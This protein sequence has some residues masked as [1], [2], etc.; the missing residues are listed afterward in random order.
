MNKIQSLFKELYYFEIEQK[1]KI[2]AQLGIPLTVLVLLIGVIAYYFKKLSI[3]LN[4]DVLSL[5]FLFLL[6]V[7]I[8]FVIADIYFLFR[9]FFGYK[10]NYLPSS[11]NLDDYVESLK[12]YYKD[13]YFSKLGQDEIDRQID[14]DVDSFL[15]R[16]YKKCLDGNI[17]NNA[18]KSKYL[19][20]SCFSL[21]FIVVFIILSSI[22]YSI[23]H[24]SYPNIQKIE[25][26]NF[27]EVV[28]M[29]NNEDKDKREKDAKSPPPK[30]KEPEIRKLSEGA[31][32]ADDE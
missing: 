29:Y 15:S 26:V 16:C 21:V 27:K 12:T 8:I 18:R 20:K 1:E 7:T 14:E 30:P 31:D 5:S 11:S 17:Y 9:V 28:R 24:Y 10:Y 2:N 19:Y 25:I 4:F 22:P 6:G 3:F 23:K 32:K 13:A